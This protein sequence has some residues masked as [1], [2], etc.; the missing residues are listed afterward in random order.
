MDPL[1]A[2][3]ISEFQ[4]YVFTG[5]RWSVQIDQVSFMLENDALLSDC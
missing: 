4:E 1:G 5:I 2:K 3:M